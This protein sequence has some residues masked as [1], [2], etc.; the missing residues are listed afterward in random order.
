MTQDDRDAALGRAVRTKTEAVRKLAELRAHA[1]HIGNRYR[2]LAEMICSEP[3]NIRFDEK[4]A[5]RMQSGFRPID[6][7]RIAE[8]DAHAI[9]TLADD[10]RAA[11][12]DAEHANAEVAKLGY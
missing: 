9:T 1:A 7:L 12:A 10:I 5:P 6:P 2:I 8:F 4:T 3:E 11:I